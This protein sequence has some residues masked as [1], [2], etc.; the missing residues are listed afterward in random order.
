MKEVNL[1]KKV[2][3]SNFSYL[4]L[5]YK[6]TFAVSYKCN[7]KCQICQI[8][9]K[10]PE[11]ELSIEEIKKFF[12][13]NNFFNWVDLTGGEVFLHS[14]IYEICK[15]IINNCNNLYLLHIP[16]NGLLPERIEKEVEKILKLKPSKFIISI[17]MDGPS[18]THDKLRGIKGNWL[19][20]V[21]TYSRLKKIKNRNFEVYFGMTLSGHNYK[22]IEKTYKSLKKVIPSLK[23]NDLHFNIAHHSSFYYSNPKVNLGLE[24]NI[25]VELQE[26]NIKKVKKFSGVSFL[27]SR[28]QKLIPKYLKTEKTPLP[29]SALNSSLFIDPHGYVYPCLIWNKK[30]AN[31]KDYDFDLGKL[32][33]NSNISEIRK[34]IRL[35]KCI[36]C[37]TPCEAY[38]TILANLTRI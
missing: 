38:Q 36:S 12:Q 28:Y 9:K 30:I 4:K 20:A 14:N 27:E 25:N 35:N 11:K 7:S 13:K 1:A 31:L 18:N 19:K 8:W 32:L 21:D 24:K 10:G 16:T 33:K 34:L 5:P 22:L 6:L 29:C 2:I 3:L 26:F 17:S 37:W 15:E 23:R